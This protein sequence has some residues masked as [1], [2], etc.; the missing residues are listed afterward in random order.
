VAQR[1][2]PAFPPGLLL[3][4]DPDDQA[5]FLASAGLNLS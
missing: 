3:F 4:H 5:A 2:T 1:K